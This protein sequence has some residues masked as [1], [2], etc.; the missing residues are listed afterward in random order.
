MT[1][2]V[3]LFT[4]NDE[5]IVE[6][7]IQ[8]YRTWLRG[9]SDLSISIVDNMSTDATQARARAA[10]AQVLTWRHDRDDLDEFLMLK[11][12]NEVWKPVEDGWI[13]VGDADEWLCVTAEDLVR[14][15]NAGTTLLQTHGVQMLGASEKADLSDIDLHSITRGKLAHEYDKPVC[16]FRRAFREINFTLGCHAAQPT[17]APRRSVEQYILKHMNWLGKEY[18]IAKHLVRHNRATRMRTQFGGIA[19]HYAGDAESIARDYNL[20]YS[21]ANV[22][23]LPL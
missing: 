19:G 3:F 12:K 16:F 17:P 14:E 21:S 8:H 6:H 20:I 22:Q 15:Q 9:C 13:I 1:I 2:N 10:G 23:T 7:A 11:M 5:H 4:Y 18:A